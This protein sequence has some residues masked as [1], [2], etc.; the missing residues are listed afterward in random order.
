MAT[1]VSLIDEKLTNAKVLFADEIAQMGEE[2]APKISSM[3]VTELV[4]G[5]LV[6]Q[7]LWL[8]IEDKNWDALRA[9]A[10]TKPDS[11]LYAHIYDLMPPERKTRLH[12][13]IS[14]F[15]NAVK[16]LLKDG[17]VSR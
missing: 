16:E 14:F 17:G 8:L 5:L 7:P 4:Q 15:L 2:L 3:G 9:F 12:N 6:A 13:Y 1:I 11:A 10:A